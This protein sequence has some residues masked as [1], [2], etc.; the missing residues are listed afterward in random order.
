MYK[1]MEKEIDKIPKPR[2]VNHVRVRFGSGNYSGQ[3]VFRIAC[4]ILIGC[5]LVGYP[6]SLRRL[7]VE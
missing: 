6:D 5:M 3:L 4:V 7:V 2:Y 1:E